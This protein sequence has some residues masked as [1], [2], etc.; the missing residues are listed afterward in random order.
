MNIIV[1]PADTFTVV[2]KTV[3][4]EEDRTVL[5]MLYQPIIGSLAVNLYFTLIS[6]LD[7]KKIMSTDLTHHMLMKSTGVSIDKL[8]EA[9]Q[10]LE[11]IGLIKTYLHESDIN[12]Y[13][14]EVYSPLKPSDFFK[15][16]FMAT[17]L[18]DAVGLS[19]FKRVKEYFQTPIIDLSNYKNIT[20]S[21]N[22]VFETVNVMDVDDIDTIKKENRL[23]IALEPTI[24]LENILSLIPDQILNVRTVTKSL[25]DLIYKLALVYNYDDEKMKSIIENSI[26]V[27]HKI[28]ANLLKENARKL[29]RFETNNSRVSLIYKN[30]PEYLKTK[31]NQ[32]SSKNKMIYRFETESPYEFLAS[33]NGCDLSKEE[34]DILKLL[35]IDIGLTPGVTNVLL[36]YVLKTS[37]NKLVK[38]FIESK[39]LE[40]KRSKIETVPDAMEKAKGERSKKTNTN[41]K[42]VKEPSW[43][44][45]E[46]DSDEM[47]EE[48]V[49][50]FKERLKN[51]E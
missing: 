10:G 18:R 31:L 2:N 13:V 9:R 25:K 8:V 49:K 43:I 21:F 35:L 38:S 51:L 32:A 17:L 39:A 42:I 46:L 24:N 45:Q 22:D 47:T 33:K 48:E 19:E 40:W 14:Y 36:D 1:M 20:L 11:A 3:L 12:N 41:R 30:Q 4:Y 50:A 7:R 27:S 5:T 26:D 29:Y 28:D 16:P 15:N 6:Y 37:D 44:N 23:G 34:T